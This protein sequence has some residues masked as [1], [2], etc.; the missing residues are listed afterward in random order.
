MC[1]SD[2]GEGIGGQSPLAN[3]IDK[4]IIHQETRI[5]C[6][7][8]GLGT[9]VCHLNGSCRRDAATCSGRSNDIVGLFF[10]GCGDRMLFRDILEGVGA[11]RSLIHAIDQ[12]L[13]DYIPC[14]GR[15]GK[16]L[17]L[18]TVYSDST[19][20]RDGAAGSCRCFDVKGELLKDN[21]NGVCLSDIVERVGIL[22]IVAAGRRIGNIYTVYQNALNYSIVV[23]VDIEGDVAIPLDI[24]FTIRC[25]G[26]TVVAGCSD[27]VVGGSWC[28]ETAATITA[29]IDFLAVFIVVAT[30]DRVYRI[31]GIVIL[32]AGAFCC[33]VSFI[34]FLLRRGS[35]FCVTGSDCGIVLRLC[36]C[37]FLL[38]CF[39]ILLQLCSFCICKSQ[40]F[41]GN[42][43]F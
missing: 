23:G 42:S 34:H 37:V 33:I 14:V 20:R 27:L 25:D 30:I 38:G 32:S 3:T 21:L 39:Q 8:E 9:T 6:D 4:K 36:Q 22:R 43:N 18:A 7:S 41:L 12:N 2:I 31:A 5:G 24:V 19:G 40:Q 29:G 1:L 35:S 11:N 16:S 28:E 26:A 15:N 10:E 17:I 13:V